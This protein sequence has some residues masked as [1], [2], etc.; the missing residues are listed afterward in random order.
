MKKTLRKFRF[1]IGK[2]FYDYKNKKE[3]NLAEISKIIFDQK[4]DKIGDA[5]VLTHAIREIKKKYPSMRID[6]L[7]GKSNF[8]ILK[9][10]TNINNL[11]IYNRKIIKKLRNEKYDLLYYNKESFYFKDFYFV[12]K[13]KA[14]FNIGINVNKINLFDIILNGEKNLRELDKYNLLLKVFHIKPESNKYD[15]FFNKEEEMF[16]I[17]NND[18]SKIIIFNRYGANKRRTLNFDNSIKILSEI[19]NKNENILI[20]LICPPSMRHENLKIKDILNDNR[21]IIPKTKNIR[22]I[23]LLIKNSDLVISPETSI[24]HLACTLDK[25]QISIYRDRNPLWHPISEKAQI[26]FSELAKKSDVNNIDLKKL[27]LLINDNL[28]E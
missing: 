13:V 16:K 5:L 24:V 22:D 11:W 17:E 1:L 23:I 21:I 19:L 25:K 20:F 8:E 18:N 4:T 15:I 3:F 14:K 27:I 28:G 9:E 6:V 10:N 12:N 26:I 7:C 2:L